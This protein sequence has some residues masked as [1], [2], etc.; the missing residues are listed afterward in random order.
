MSKQWT[1]DVL[2]VQ[3][4][5]P[6]QSTDTLYANG[7]MQVQ[8]IVLIYAVEIDESKEEK[9]YHLSQAEL[10]SIE[11]VD[12]YY[13]NTQLTGDWSYSN[14]YNGWY[15]TL[16]PAA[17]AT[18]TQAILKASSD[19]NV[20]Q[21]KTYW[22]TTTAVENKNIAA[23]IKQPDGKVITSRSGMLD[24][25][26][27][28]TGKSPII[29][30]T[31]K[32]TAS[33]EDTSEGTYPFY[34][35]IKGNELNLDVKKYENVH[36]DQKNYYI[37]TVNHPLMKAEI[38]GYDSDGYQNGNQYSYR[39]MNCYAYSTPDKKNLKLYYIWKY[40]SEARKVTGLRRE[41]SIENES[42]S[43]KLQADVEAFIS[44][45]QKPNA[46]CLTRMAVDM[47][48]FKVYQIEGFWGK[49][50][51]YPCWF[52]LW[53]V[54]G[55]S[56]KFSASFSENDNTIRIGNSNPA[57]HERA[58]AATPILRE[59]AEADSQTNISKGRGITETTEGLIIQL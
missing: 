45:N 39:L 55:N 27:T 58:I 43:I 47:Y 4:T 59:T 18:T 6:S 17:T 12:Y 54:Y 11:L 30:T 37:S 23:R 22:V 36:W 38:H 13:T 33:Q 29:Y 25:H 50:W 7:R 16:E 34:W 5:T 42:W 41:E 20:S 40:G 14:T 32:I 24:S 56:G 10:D 35:E 28:L 21:P 46:L 3:T 8:V 15:Q 52:E 19:S 53:D 31:D 44:V 1:V 51:H 57:V 26:V 2:K 49:E 9:Q 48:D